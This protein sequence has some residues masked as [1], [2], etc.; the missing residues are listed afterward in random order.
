[1]VPQVLDRYRKYL[2]GRHSYKFVLSCDEDDTTMNN[3]ET[4]AYLDRQHDLEYHFNP[5]PQTKVSAINANLE[6]QKATVIFAMS[7]DMIPVEQ[8]FDEIIVRELL[9]RFPDTN[10]CLWFD[11]GL[12]P[13]ICTLSIIGWKYFSEALDHRIYDPRYVSF[14]CDD[15]FTEVA[16]RDGRMARINQVIVQHAWVR[17]TG[18]DETHRRNGTRDIQIRDTR[19]FLHLRAAGFPKY[20]VSS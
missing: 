14:C 3:P 16:M 18:V 8:G 12:N 11:D 1:M 10:G 4:R 19:T 20:G 2:S 9:Q 13:R 7:D 17:V 15:H 6:G 5:A